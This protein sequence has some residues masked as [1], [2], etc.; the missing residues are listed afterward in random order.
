MQIRNVLEGTTI[1]KYEVGDLVTTPFGPGVIMK[2]L[3]QKREDV[4]FSVILSDEARI[5]NHLEN[6]P[7]KFGSFELHGIIKKGG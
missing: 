3:G 4:Y 7:Y 5:E 2:E 1:G 6:R